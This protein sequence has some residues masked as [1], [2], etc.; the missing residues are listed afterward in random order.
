MLERLQKVLATA[1]IA[2]RREAEKIILA[3]RVSV[4]G[5]VV[6]VLGTKVD[7]A[8]DRVSLDGRPIP[9]RPRHRYI[10]LNKPAG[11]ITTMKDP[12]G[13]PLVSDLLTGVTERLFPVGRLDYNTEGLL[14]LTNDGD[15]ANR[16]AH[17]SH[18]IEKQY[19]VRVRGE[20]LPE[21]LAS[22]M[23]GVPI[24]GRP[25]VASPATLIKSSDSNCWISITITE[26]RY[27]LVRRMCEAVGLQVVR[28]RR[29]RY[30]R[31][32]LG[33]LPLGKF[34]DLTP[35]EVLAVTEELPVPVKKRENEG[36]RP[37]API[38]GKRQ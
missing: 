27:R 12:E 4:N 29:V 20:A 8:G 32:F 19:H 22:L 34:R 18:S 30:G 38:R 14:L 28:L 37:S 33:E 31:I 5:A 35:V 25:A 7:P 26:G 36:R 13:R 24:D 6:T 9:L 17:P 21:Q 23:A 2:S 10:I 1:G 15:W 11:Y 3:G 16:L